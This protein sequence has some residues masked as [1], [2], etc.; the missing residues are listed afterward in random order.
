MGKLFDPE[1]FKVFPSTINRLFI[2]KLKVQYFKINTFGR[3]APLNI[4][5]IEDEIWRRKSGLLVYI[6]FNNVK[7]DSESNDGVFSSGRIKIDPQRRTRVFTWD[8]WYFAALSMFDCSYWIAYYFNNEPPIHFSMDKELAINKIAE[9]GNL[10]IRVSLFPN[11]CRSKETPKS[12]L[13]WRLGLIT[14]STNELKTRR[15][16]K[17][18]K[19]RQRRFLPL[20]TET[21][22]KTGGS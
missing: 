20:V 19:T 11:F 17:I 15:N 2:G 6:S 22:L 16:F 3:E 13:A 10:P 8:T 5:F 1:E 14:T 18:S 7:P 21:S 4:K 12:G 9:Q